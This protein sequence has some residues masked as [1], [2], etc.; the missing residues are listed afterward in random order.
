[1][2]IDLNIACPSCY[3]LQGINVGLQAREVHLELPS[4][5]KAKM[6]AYECDCGFYVTQ[7]QFLYQEFRVRYH[8]A[9]NVLLHIRGWVQPSMNSTS[10]KLW[11]I[12]Q[13]VEHYFSK[14]NPVS[15]N[16]LKLWKG[17]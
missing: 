5:R 4:G 1:M 15:E 3:R 2:A 9:L 13:A 8:Q 17:E 6:F 10:G 14:T 12:R 16:S 7:H 11:V